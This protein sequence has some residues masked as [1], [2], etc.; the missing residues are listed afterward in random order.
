MFYH[1]TRDENWRSIQKQ[2]LKGGVRDH[3]D[4]IGINETSFK[5]KGRLFFLDTDDKRVWNG[6]SS[7]Q[8]Q[9]HRLL[10][11]SSKSFKNWGRKNSRKRNVKYLDRKSI[12]NIGRNYV[13]IGIPKELFRFLGITI[14]NDPTNEI[15]NYDN[16]HKFVYLGNKSINPK[17]LSVVYNG[18]DDLKK[19]EQE[20]VWEIKYET[21]KKSDPTI[22]K[23]DL[24]ITDITGDL[25]SYKDRH[26][27]MLNNGWLYDRNELMN[28]PKLK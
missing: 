22:K 2:G 18:V 20:E 23:E 24:T 16:N 25:I 15:I 1:I 28:R 21:L 9:Q 19:H 4:N 11:V 12:K 14:Y 5:L 27:K 26:D 17:F 3:Y 7:N 6:I 13:V 8:I 10:K